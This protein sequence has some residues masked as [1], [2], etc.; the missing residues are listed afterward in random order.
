VT[1]TVPACSA[2]VTVAVAWSGD[3]GGGSGVASYDLDVSADGAPWEPL[4]TNTQS[5]SYQYTGQP[6][7]RYTFRVTATDNVG[8]EGQGEADTR[9]A[10]VTK[11]YYFGGR[12]VAMRGPDG[13]YY[14]HAD[15][16]GS[17]SLTTDDSGEVVARQ[18][19]HPFGTV[20]WSEGTLPTDFGFT[21]QRHDGTGLVFMHARYYHPSLGRFISA[22]TIVPGA[23]NPQAFNRY[24]WVFNNPL[25][26]VDPS[27]HDPL[28]DQWQTEFQEYHNRPPNWYDRLIRLYSIAF[29]EEWDWNTFYDSEGNLRWVGYDDWGNLDD[30]ERL[31]KA[32][33]RNP[34]A[35]RSWANM[36]AAL[37]RLA[38]WYT[39]GEESAFVR[40]VGALFGGLLDRFV[41]P[42][43][44]KAI[45]HGGNPV[46]VWAGLRP[47]GISSLYLDGD[48]DAN[49]HHWA[50]GF[51]LGYWQGPLPFSGW[52]M[53]TGRELK[54][55]L[56]D[57]KGYS[58]ADVEL[59]NLG[60][61][62]GAFLQLP[63]VSFKRVGWGFGISEND[64]WYR[65]FL[66]EYPFQPLSKPIKA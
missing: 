10:A 32:V 33:F 1:V 13:V 7:H 41:E 38:G 39:K 14:L 60:V 51:V 62:Q 35:S 24:S 25:V 12:R 28:D 19:Y 6:G 55:G 16:L 49:V 48:W 29:P 23:A 50:W 65:F 11:Y 64:F 45:S 66:P 20:R 44:W 40:D 15:H 2:V 18:L 9:V 52:V 3:D 30:T 56:I 17:T 26:Y 53:N 57:R 27:G 63:F 46:H 54:Q 42:D 8:N 61:S 21:G 59:G 43:M 22:D 47:Y 31:D 58:N 37:Q 36:P 5:T 34:G 4:L